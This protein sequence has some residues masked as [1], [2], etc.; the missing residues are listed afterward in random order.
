MFTDFQSCTVKDTSSYLKQ[1]VTRLQAGSLGGTAC[2]DALKELQR[3]SV[4]GRLEVQHS[5]ATVATWH[6]QQLTL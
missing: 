1:V 3:R 2:Q 6:E 5:S 4:K